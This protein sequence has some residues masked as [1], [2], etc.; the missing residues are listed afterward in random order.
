M[1][2]YRDPDKV[3]STSWSR[4]PDFWSRDPDFLSWDPKMIISRSWLHISRS[5]HPGSRSQLS[6]SRSWDRISRSRERIS[7][8]L[9]RI[10]RS[11]NKTFKCWIPNSATVLNILNG[12]IIYDHI[13]IKE[14]DFFSSACGIYDMHA[15]VSRSWDRIS[16]SR[17]RISRSLV[18]ISRSWNKTFKCWI[19]NSATVLN[20]LNGYIIYDHINIKEV[21]FFSSACG[22]YDMH[23]DVMGRACS[24]IRLCKYWADLDQILHVGCVALV[25]EL[26]Y[27]FW[28]LKKK[29]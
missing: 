11:W 28:F 15:D 6:V 26:P 10:S 24:G 19:P 23:A 3:I 20:I 29:K 27:D 4:D 5:R 8:S 12:Y 1:S 18:R 7:R 14:V 16:R 22:I 2:R 9:V 25:M 21:D 17:E 13:N